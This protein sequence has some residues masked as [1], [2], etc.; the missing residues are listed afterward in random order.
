MIPSLGGGGEG[1]AAAP[2]RCCAVHRRAR[3]AGGPQLVTAPGHWPL[4]SRLTAPGQEFTIPAA[5]GQP[6]GPRQVI[7]PGHWPLHSR[8]TAPGQEFTIPDAVG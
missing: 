1:K 5:V 2:V 4:R 6:G 3:Q 7:A 8:L